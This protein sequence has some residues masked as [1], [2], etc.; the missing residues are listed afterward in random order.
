MGD[1][2]KESCLNQFYKNIKLK[3][4]D[5]QYDF[6][7]STYKDMK[8]PIEVSCKEHGVFKIKPIDL[9]RA[10]YACPICRKRNHIYKEID[11]LIQYA[12]H[13]KYILKEPIVY[14][15]S[16]SKISI[17]CPE[18]GEFLIRPSDFLQGK[19][20]PKCA[21]NYRYSTEEWIQK[22]KE[23]HKDKYDYSK[24]IYK[25]WKTPIQIICPKHG[26]FYMDS[27]HHLRGQGCP[28]C[29]ESKLESEIK[30]MLD[31]LNIQYVQQCHSTTFKWLK[32]Q[33]L[34]FYIPS[35]KLAIECQ[36]IQHFKQVDYFSS[37]TFQKR[38]K[39][40]EQKFKLC[41]K[42]GIKL[43]YYTH[44]L[45]PKDFKYTIFTNLDAVI[46]EIEAIEI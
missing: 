34:D 2:R 29:N 25:D 17:I 11:K 31:S 35:L 18:H 7:I 41:Q 20:C 6:S 33:S 38:I 21:G 40:D 3:K 12:S 4:L 1:H 46:K 10:S 8:T 37:I 30:D 19:G 22:A 23:I 16:T 13:T 26:S 32:H 28:Y 15:N 43:I 14:K 36:G 44:C 42:N 27:N 24:S 9:F 45:I 39:L 5:R